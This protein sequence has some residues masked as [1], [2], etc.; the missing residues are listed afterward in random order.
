MLINCSILTFPRTLLILATELSG[1]HPCPRKI[2]TPIQPLHF[3]N[4]S[5]NK[6]YFKNLTYI[7]AVWSTIIFKVKK[8]GFYPP[9][10]VKF[11]ANH[12]DVDFNFGSPKTNLRETFLKTWKLI[13]GQQNIVVLIRYPRLSSPLIQVKLKMQHATFS[14]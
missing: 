13:A 1:C 11:K 7:K 8:L 10:W 6:L 12:T 4:I 5:S 3:R 14:E 2:W 9:K